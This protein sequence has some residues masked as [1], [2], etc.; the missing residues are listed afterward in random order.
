MGDGGGAQL[1]PYLEQR[2]KRHGRERREKETAKNAKYDKEEAEAAAALAI[3][4]GGGGGGGGGA[5]ASADE[6]G[7]AGRRVVPPWRLCGSSEQ[8]GGGLRCLCGALSC[9]SYSVHVP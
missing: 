8:R 9:S 4:G 6:L 7:A 1:P 3:D 5:G 2:T